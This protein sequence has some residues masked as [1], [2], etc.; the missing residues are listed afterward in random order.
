MAA[1]Q[2]RLLCLIAESR[3]FPTVGEGMIKTNFLQKLFRAVVRS[4]SPLM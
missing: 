3:L 2:A 1:N 4:F